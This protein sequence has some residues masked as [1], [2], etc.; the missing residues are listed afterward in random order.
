LGAHW[1]GVGLVKDFFKF[2]SKMQGIV[3]FYREK[4]YLWPET[5]TKGLIDPGAEDV[6]RTA[7]CMNI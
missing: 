1:G 5:G 3:H 2:S 6:K 4:N 7:G